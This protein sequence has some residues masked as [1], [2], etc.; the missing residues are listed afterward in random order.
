LSTLALAFAPSKVMVTLNIPSGG[1][2]IPLAVVGA[3][4]TTGFAW[5]L[6]SRVPAAG[7]NIF[8]RMT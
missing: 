4:T 5:Q 3:P 2:V 6:A 1:T 8:Y 7:Y